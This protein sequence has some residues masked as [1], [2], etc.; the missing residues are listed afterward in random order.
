MKYY[1]QIISTLLARIAELEKRVT[2]QA[3]RIAELEKRLNKNSS[4]SSKP[5]SS[6]GLRKPPRTTSL[7][8]NG[9]HKSGGHKGHKGTTLKQV[10][11]ADHGVTHKLEECP[12]CGRSLAKQA[13]KGII[14]RQVFD[15]PIVQVEVTEHRAEMKFC[16]CC[17]KQVTASFP[18]EVKAH[19]Q[20]GNRVRS[21]IVYYQN[22]HLIP[23]ARIQH[24]KIRQQIVQLNRKS[25]CIRNHT[26][27]F[28][29]TNTI[30]FYILALA[31]I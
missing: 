15:L 7:R 29:L 4:N 11:H 31:M 24:R 17:Q 6:D 14:K 22:Q 28:W 30:M 16:S 21:W 8:E 25:I 1:E 26:F 13:A 2:Q 18:S 9:K 5:P 19:A 23:E 20:Y 3:A 27:T 10:V 12:D